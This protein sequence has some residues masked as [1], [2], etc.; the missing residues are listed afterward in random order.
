ML[1]TA[2]EAARKVR[3][4][5][6][7]HGTFWK[8]VEAYKIPCKTEI[9]GGKIR[10]LFRSEDIDNYLENGFVNNA[11]VSCDGKTFNRIARAKRISIIREIATEIKAGRIDNGVKNTDRK[12]RKGGKRIGRINESE[13][14]SFRAF[15][16]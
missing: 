5:L 7:K 6:S 4:G 14:S 2:K 8:W 1:L 10:K 3:R 13:P 15:T 16:N 9:V 11:E 12:V